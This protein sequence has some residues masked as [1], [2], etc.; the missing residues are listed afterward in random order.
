MRDLPDKVFW[1]IASRESKSE[2]EALYISKIIKIFQKK[3]KKKYRS[4][5]EVACGNGRL[6]P[7]L[8]KKG[9]EVFGIDSSEELLNEAYSKD[10]K[11]RKNY[12]K[13]DMRNFNLRR[14]FD[15]VLSW[16]TSFG[17]YDDTVNIKILKNMRK[18]LIKNGLLIVEIPN[19]ISN[20]KRMRRTR[21]VDYDNYK[22]IIYTKFEIINNQTFW[23][24]RSKFYLKK[25]SG[26][27][28]VD[29]VF[30]KVRIYDAQEITCLLKRAGFE[31]IQIY[32]SGMFKKSRKNS[33]RMLVLARN[34]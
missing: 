13:A 32:R 6:H 19:K 15:V 9:F 28:L 5:L 23:A 17:Y 27:K 34:N 21:T 29:D 26:L 24:F 16:F 31:N 1:H 11:N 25:G 22:E 4:I 2:K 30:R 33:R 7:F 18:H 8:R 12:W 20:M 10:A 3:A 14:K